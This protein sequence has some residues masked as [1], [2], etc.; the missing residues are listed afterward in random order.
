MIK[1]GPAE[2]GKI[3]AFLGADG[4]GVKA[5]ASREEADAWLARF[6]GDA[7]VMAY[8]GRSGWNDLTFRGA[9]PDD[10]LVEAVVDSYRRVVAKLP[11]KHRPDG[12]DRD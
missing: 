8:I 11:R 2:A 4:V 6:P 1:V 5:G 12:W 10:E 3:F 7:S 9:I